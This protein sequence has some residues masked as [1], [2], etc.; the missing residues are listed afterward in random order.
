MDRMTAAVNEETDDVFISKPC[1]EEHGEGIFFFKN[2]EEFNK[3][4]EGKGCV[5]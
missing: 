3:D 5:V 1:D 4:Y 2:L